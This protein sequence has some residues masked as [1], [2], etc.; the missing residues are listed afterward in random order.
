MRVITF[1]SPVDH[2]VKWMNI[3]AMK[4]HLFIPRLVERK[5]IIICKYL[6][7]LPAGDIVE[8]SNS[9]KF[10]CRRDFN[11]VQI[12]FSFLVD[13]IISEWMGEW[14]TFGEAVFLFISSASFLE[15]QETK[16][17]NIYC[18]FIFLSFSQEKK[19]KQPSTKS[20]K[21]QYTKSD[22]HSP[23]RCI[24]LRSLLWNSK[25][26]FMSVAQVICV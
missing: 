8:W 1:Q 21:S 20:N 22:L 4:R 10:I 17:Y 26:V 3:T 7:F 11:I 5:L 19:R 25:L 12:S 9:I 23:S 14:M 18:F 13:D 6:L 16:A 24:I 2:I 15:L